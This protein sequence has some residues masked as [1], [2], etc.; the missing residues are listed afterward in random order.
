MKV[1][2][3]LFC[4]LF[5]PFVYAEEPVKPASDLVYQVKS[6]DTLGKLAN[7]LLDNAKRWR[8]VARYNQLPDANRIEPGQMLRIQQPWLRSKAGML[9]V[10]A[11]TGLA[12]AGGKEIKVGDEL[13]QGAQIETTASSALRLRLP[14]GSLLNMME[15]SQLQV[16]KLEQRQGDAFFSLFRLLTGQVETFKKKYPEGMSDLAI[17]AKTAT[18]GVR[19]THFRMREEGGR[20]YAEIEQGL[21]SYDAQKTPMVLALA[22][23]QGSVA[24]GEY[25]AEVVNLLPPPTFP[26]LPNEF[27]TPYIQWTMPELEGATGFF[28]E[29][30]R[31]EEFSDH[32]VSVRASKRKIFLRDLPN[33]RYW[34]RLRAVDGRGLQGMEGK[35]SFAVNVPPRKFA[36]T[37]V[38]VTGTGVQLRWVGRKEGG[39]YQVQVAD[40]LQFNK[41]MLDTRTSDNLVEI[42]RPKQGQYFMRVRQVFSGG[43]TDSWDVPMLFEAPR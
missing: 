20:A 18:L 29:L 6:G 33:G 41:P 42:A 27:D 43:V 36:M 8:D 22:G 35:V 40:N 10:E 23:G 12:K 1:A 24:D 34:L 26:S 2:A 14:D 39:G 4:L 15:S 13:S 28:G 38:Y 9:K 5:S 11:V 25:A 31:D 7:E 37:K 32:L 16:E 19:G 17:R 21:V 3:L 30:A